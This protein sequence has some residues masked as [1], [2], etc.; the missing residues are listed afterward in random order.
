MHPRSGRFN[1]ESCGSDFEVAAKFAMPPGVAFCPFCGAGEDALTVRGDHDARSRI[2]K[3]N[4]A[5]SAYGRQALLSKTK[6]EA[7]PC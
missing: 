6:V 3:L 7:K 2:P 5:L 1:C 4:K